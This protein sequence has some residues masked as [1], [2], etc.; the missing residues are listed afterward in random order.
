MAVFVICHGAWS[1]AWAWKKI[2]PLLRAAGHEILTP[3][4]TGLGERAH[5]TGP[6]VDLDLHI[7][8]VVS[9]IEYEDVQDFV[10]VGHSYGGM[11]ATGVADRVPE[12]VRHLVYLDAFVPQHGQSL[13]DL[14]LAGGAVA[15]VGVEGWLAPPN[16][17]PADTSP[18]DMAWL[19]LRRR[20]QPIRTFTQKLHLQTGAPSLPR[21]YI[22]GARKDGVDHFRQFA[23]RAKADPAWSF[24]ERDWSHSPNV[25]APEP[26][27]Q[28]LA[29]IAAHPRYP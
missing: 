13:N 28:L 1:S 9:V 6:R 20:H 15:H 21:T 12:R 3:T 18:E 5:L 24:Y 14:R 10:L 2:R 7:Q 4:Y 22:Y 23:E 26:L 11:V 27:A 19:A 25:T 8:D 16:P 29:E 17:S